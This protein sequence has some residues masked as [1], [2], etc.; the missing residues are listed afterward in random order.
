MA[1]YPSFPE[2]IPERFATAWNVKNADGIGALFTEDADF[3]NVVGLWWRRK[4]RIWKAH[5]IGLRTFFRDSTLTVEH[6]EVKY[7]T[8][9][10][11]T[12]HARWRIEG[13]YTPDGRV[14]APRT[15]IFVFVARH[16]SDGWIC[17]TAQNT[18]ILPGKESI[19]V[20]DGGQAR[21]AAYTLPDA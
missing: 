18:D 9:E 12:V 15:G 16:E 10:V 13:Q 14:A 4:Q 20:E 17:T 8:E 2:G 21:G 3:V 5:E 1:P 19:V 11:A 6:T 7:I